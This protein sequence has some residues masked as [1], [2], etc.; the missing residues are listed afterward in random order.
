MV[1]LQVLFHD[2]RPEMS[3]LDCVVE[4]VASGPH[5]HPE[6]GSPFT[7]ALRHGPAADLPEIHQQFDRW[8]EESNVIRAGTTDIDG[9][10]YL[11]LASDDDVMLLEIEDN[12]SQL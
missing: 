4:T 7:V 12:S 1:V 3:L 9:M 10:P 5:S 11:V 6:V 8:A 2:A